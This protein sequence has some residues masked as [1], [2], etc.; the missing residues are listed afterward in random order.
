MSSSIIGK[1]K[2]SNANFIVPENV[3][4]SMIYRASHAGTRI[5]PQDGFEIFPSVG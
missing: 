5:F 3:D 1:F 4:I 2:L